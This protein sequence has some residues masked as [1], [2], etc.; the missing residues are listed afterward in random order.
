MRQAIGFVI[1]LWALSQFMQ[2]TFTAADAALTQSF[3]TVETAA[4]VA[5]TRFREI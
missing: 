2:S 3:K 1:I 4:A 5:E